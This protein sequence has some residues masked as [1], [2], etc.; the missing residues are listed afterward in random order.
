MTKLLD[1]IGNWNPQLF[2]E[3]KGRFR[4][5][6]LAIAVGTSLVAQIMMLLGY[7]GGLPD[8]LLRETYNRYCTGYND[9]YWRSTYQCIS[10]AAGDAWQV[11]WQLWNFDLFVG[12]SML[13]A[14]VLLVIGSHLISADL[15][16]EEKRGTLGFVRLSPQAL[17]RII[18]GKILGVPS[19]IYLGIALALPLHLWVGLQAGITLPW[20][21]MVDLVIIGACI[22]SYSLATLISFVGQDF[23]GGFQSWLY[24]GSLGFYLMVTSIMGFDSNFPV[25]NSFDWLRLF[26]PGNIFYYIVDSN[27]L[28]PEVIHYFEPSGLFSTEFFHSTAWSTGFLGLV[29]MAGHYFVLTSI[30][31]E[32]IQRRFYE[33]Q[34][35]IIS[36]RT[37][38]IAAILTTFMLVGFVAV[39]NRDYRLLGNFEGL[40]VFYLLLFFTLTF[41]LTPKRQRVQDWFRD[42]QTSRYAKQFWS[43]LL[44]GDR[45]PALL[46]IAVML[47]FSTGI[48]AIVAIKD[49]LVTETGA[50]LV[51]LTL[52]AGFLFICACI[53]QLIFLQTRK[54][55]VLLVVSLSTLTIAPFLVYIIFN[56]RFP[57]VVALGLFSAFPINAAVDAVAHLALWAIA[58][59]CIAMISGAWYIQ[60]SIQNIGA[61]EL[62]TLLTPPAESSKN[63]LT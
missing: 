47:A 52:Q 17:H 60:R 20:I 14:V 63:M 39:G 33:P 46:A 5:R 58:G 4:R 53:V 41:C 40:Q 18:I 45:S 13:G 44:W 25:N 15:I 35:T 22:A 56:H 7:S 11:N 54:Q 1:Q 29:L 43:D 57:S 55:G 23:F 34:A 19:L 59:Q 31:W 28:E 21:G 6:N 49:P 9:E 37:G 32:G 3:L 26:Y 30:S 16:K 48:M 38:Y 50:V 27:S 12:L 42:R 2:R 36:K 10:T 62:K 24:S 61:S 8:P 51:G